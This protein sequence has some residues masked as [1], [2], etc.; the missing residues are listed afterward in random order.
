MKD[1]N[2]DLVL[3]PD[4][5]PILTNLIQEDVTPSSVKSGQASPNN[6]LS[7]DELAELL[8]NSETF[9]QQLDEIA[10]ELT[11]SVREQIELALRP[12]LEE[13]VSL[14]LDDSGTASYEAVRKQLMATLPELLART[15]QD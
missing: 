3:D 1:T 12:V 5:I 9:T 14:A 15:L 7:V 2:E 13:A 6:E 11:R 10:A 8:L 4:G